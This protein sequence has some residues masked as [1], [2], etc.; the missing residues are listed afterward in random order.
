MITAQK[1]FRQVKN[2]RNFSKNLFVLVT[3]RLELLLALVLRNLLA[4]FFLQIAHLELSLVL[5]EFNGLFE[6]MC[7]AN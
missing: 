5:D 6:E 4:A 3:H 2:F 1:K 7:S